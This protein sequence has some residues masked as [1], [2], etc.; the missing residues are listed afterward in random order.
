MFGA[1]GLRIRYFHVSLQLHRH[2]TL[3]TTSTEVGVSVGSE[4][5]E[6]FQRTR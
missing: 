5:K 3:A 4:G 1:L 6:R 2:H